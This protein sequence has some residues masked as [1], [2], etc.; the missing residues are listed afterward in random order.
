M[1]LLL[2]LLA[3]LLL[4]GCRP[5][6]TA[7]FPYDLHQPRAVYELPERLDELSGLVQL[8]WRFVAGVSDRQGTFYVIDLT[9]GRVV[10][11]QK[12]ADEGHYEDIARVGGRFFIIERDGVLFELTNLRSRSPRVER[13]VLDVPAGLMMEGIVHDDARDRLLLGGKDV[14]AGEG[15]IFAYDLNR[16]R[17]D[18]TPV[19]RLR[20]PD[21]L[22]HV[23]STVARR[24]QASPFL[25]SALAVQPGTQHLYVLS[26]DTHLLVVLNPDW[27]VR[28]VEMLPVTLFPEP[29]GLTFLP[30]G[31]LYISNEETNDA[32][33]S[34][35]RARIVRLSYRRPGF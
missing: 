31:E 8:D 11:E 18:P 19:H 7:S 2:P 25:P 5:E 24:L 20:T 32:T 16:R 21:L 30:N 4:A 6:R 9:D 35:L 14:A 22:A 12:F 23:D 29:E 10:R 13:H 1:R 28:T 34:Q 27:S 3:A 15:F 33:G 17:F 26:E